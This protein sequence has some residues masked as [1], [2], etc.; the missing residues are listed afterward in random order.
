MCGGSLITLKHILTAAHCL[1][2]EDKPNELVDIRYVGLSM[3]GV[4]K[5]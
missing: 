2:K 3:N 5:A 1:M 4:I